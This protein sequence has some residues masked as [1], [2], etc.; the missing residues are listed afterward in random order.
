MTSTIIKGLTAGEKD[1]LMRL[2]NNVNMSRD[3][4]RIR[5]WKREVIAEVE[6][7]LSEHVKRKA[8]KYI[9]RIV[10]IDKEKQKKENEDRFN[11]IMK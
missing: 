11:R 8:T 4:G 3:P 7:V 2:L 9:E 10:Y 5:Y 6:K 1:Q